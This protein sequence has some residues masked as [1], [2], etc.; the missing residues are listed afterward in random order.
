MNPR[1]TL[2]VCTACGGKP[3]I[4]G[5]KCQGEKLLEQLHS[6]P[7]A[8]P[9]DCA[10]QGVKCM[11]VCDHSCAIAFVGAG[12]FTYLFGDL[13]IESIDSS[14][15][16][17]DT[18]LDCFSK[19]CDDPDGLLPYRDRPELLRDTIIAK[20]PSAFH[21]ELMAAQKYDRHTGCYERTCMTIA[22]LESRM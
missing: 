1:A 18:V 4:E 12:K 11:G 3:M 17:L 2:F 10:I 16:V 6:H 14:A 20:I 19:Y 15:T 5:G 13:L 7:I 9:E 22:R 8:T 21:P